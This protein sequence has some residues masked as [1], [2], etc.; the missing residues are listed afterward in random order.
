MLLN[1]FEFLWFFPLITA[2]YF[3]APQ[4]WRTTVLFAAGMWFYM[5][6]KPV[7]VLVP[8]GCV[9]AAYTGGLLL[10]KRDSRGRRLARL[11]AAACVPL[12]MLLLFK[13]YGFFAD[14]FESIGKQLR[15]SWSIPALR[16]ALP[17]G[18]SF[19]TFKTL[20]YLFDVYHG[21]YPAQRNL[22]KLATY[23]T[24]F[25]QI[26]AGPIERADNFIPQLDTEHQFDYRRVMDGLA[27]ILW[28]LFKKAVIADRLAMVANWVY[29]SPTEYSGFPLIIAT[30][31]YAFQIYCDFS[32]YSDMAIGAGRVLGFSTMRNFDQPYLS[33]SVS[34]FWRRWHIS[35]STWFRDYLYIPLGG[36][37]VQLWKWG[38]N[39]LIVFLVSGLWHGSRWTFIIWGGLHGLYLLAERL[40]KPSLAKVSASVGLDRHP[41]LKGALQLLLTFHLVTFAWIFFR[42]DSVGDALYVVS[43]LFDGLGSGIMTALSLFRAEDL[44]F[45][46]IFVL[47]LEAAHL[48]QRRY[49]SGIAWLQA[50]PMWVRWAIYAGMVLAVINL[51]PLYQSQF[52][53]MQF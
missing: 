25:P 9:A 48:L 27:L 30:Y 12:G 24:F 20:S 26:M 29:L 50:R 49:T 28:G 46:L 34:E 51:R 16:L 22:L 17:L 40:L 8:L 42:A 52:I 14:S 33:R 35:L 7:L 2:I 36:S 19:F 37:R 4:R 41:R 21:K 53:Y 5:A 39:V 47:L 6:W 3:A 10:E 45:A 23:I 1:S 31:A 15:A 44:W 38:R 11:F 18:I 13:Y 43:H 32:G